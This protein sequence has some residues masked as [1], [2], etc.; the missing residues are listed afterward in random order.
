MSLP[1]VVNQPIT[2]HLTKSLDEIRQ[3]KDIQKRH[4]KES[5]APELR[6]TTGFVTAEY[7]ISLLEKCI[8]YFRPLLQKKVTR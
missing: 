5:I 1:K 4:Q 8:V 2:F 6:E 3:I 7:E